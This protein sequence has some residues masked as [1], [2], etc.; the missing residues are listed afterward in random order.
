MS[1]TGGLDRFREYAVPAITEKQGLSNSF[2]GTILHARDG[3]IWLGTLNG[4]DRWKNGDVV[5]YGEKDGLPDPYVRSLFEDQ[6]GRIWIST[7]R[8]VA[9]L[10]RGKFVRVSKIASG[11]VV[12]IVGDGAGSIWIGDQ[13][14]LY[15]LRGGTVVEEIPWTKLGHKDFASIILPDPLRGGLW[16]GFRQGG[17][18]YYKDDAIRLSYGREQGFGQGQVSGVKRDGFDLGGNWRRSESY[19]KRFYLPAFRCERITVRYGSLGR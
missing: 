2:V 1:E 14:S 13:L 19:Q 7:R 12:C 10:E 11:S 17:I 6:A 8:G 15:H 4:L 5:V 9:Y 3:S 18:A 16:L